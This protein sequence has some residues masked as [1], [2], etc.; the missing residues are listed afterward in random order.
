MAK[1]EQFSWS[2]DEAQLLLNITLEYKLEN[3]AEGVDW[4]STRNKYEDNDLP[5]NSKA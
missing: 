3:V 4:E 1:K 2:D 5:L